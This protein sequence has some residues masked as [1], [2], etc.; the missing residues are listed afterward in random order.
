[1]GVDY[2]DLM[3]LHQPVGDYLGAWRAMEEAVKTGKI[4]S[5]GLSNFTGPELDKVLAE[6]TI[7]PALVQVECH[8]YFQQKDL[9]A[10]LAKD[11]IA[12]EAWYPLASADKDLLAEPIFAELASKYNKSVVQ[13]SCIGMSKQEILSFQALKIQLT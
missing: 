4:K 12:L 10:K 1:M 8:P 2:L 6:G 9:K 5:I 7:K 11:T 3:L 13:S